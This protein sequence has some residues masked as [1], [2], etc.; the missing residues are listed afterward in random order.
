[1]GPLAAQALRTV[2]HRM[3]GGSRME[4][5]FPTGSGSVRFSYFGYPTR[6]SATRRL[7]GQRCIVPPWSRSAS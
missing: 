4:V 7:P 1:M 6:P 3:G 2:E 5:R